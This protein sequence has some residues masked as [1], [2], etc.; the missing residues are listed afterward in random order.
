MHIIVYA[1]LIGAAYILY[2]NLLKPYLTRK[3]FE[4]QGVPTMPGYKPI[5]GHVGLFS[6]IS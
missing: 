3:R 4:A 1:A 5:L 2:M 6:K